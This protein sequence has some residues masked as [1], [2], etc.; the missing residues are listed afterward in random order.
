MSTEST[1]LPLPKNP[2]MGALLIPPRSKNFV[3]TQEPSWVKDALQEAISGEWV[4]LEGVMT[5]RRMDE[6]LDVNLEMTYGVECP[7]EI[8]GT[9]V[10]YVHSAVVELVYQPFT[11]DPRK[12]RHVKLPQT[13]KD[14]ERI[15]HQVTIQEEELDVGWYDDGELD[16][17][18]VLTEAIVL[19]RP[20]LLSCAHEE[21]QRLEDG[22]CVEFP[23][24]GQKNTY[25]PFANLPDLG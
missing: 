19:E 7:C 24:E 10:R 5:L 3:L 8:C 14:L 17:S 11:M 18:M 12:S 23:T 22:D 9:P 4:Q 21:T 16:L 6:R 2:K 25:K 15:S 20:T 1:N 13:V